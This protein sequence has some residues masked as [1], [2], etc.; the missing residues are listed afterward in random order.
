MPTLLKVSFGAQPRKD[1]VDVVFVDHEGNTISDQTKGIIECAQIGTSVPMPKG[2]S[3]HRLFA[4]VKRALLVVSVDTKEKL[5]LYDICALGG[6]VTCILQKEH[7]TSAR[8]FCESELPTDLNSVV[9]ETALKEFIHGIQTPTYHFDDLKKRQP[10]GTALKWVQ[11]LSTGIKNQVAKEIN[12]FVTRLVTSEHL[13]RRWIDTPAGNG[14]QTEDAV[15]LA[16]RI[17]EGAGPQC[18]IETI[19]G[20]ELAR[21]GMH[22]LYQVGVGSSHPPAAVILRW[23]GRSSDDPYDAIIGKFLVHDTGGEDAKPAGQHANMKADMGGGAMALATFWNAV[24]SKTKV[25]LIVGLAVADNCISSTSRH[26]GTVLSIYKGPSVEDGHTDAE[27]RLALADVIR[28]VEENYGP[29]RLVTIATLTG[30]AC[31]ALGLD[32][33]ALFSKTGSMRKV[34]EEA[35]DRSG[36]PVWS[37]PLKEARHTKLLPGKAGTPADTSQVGPKPGGSITAAKFLLLECAQTEHAAHLD[38]A[39]VAMECFDRVGTKAFSTGYGP[40]L[41]SSI[42]QGFQWPE[43]EQS[44]P[45]SGLDLSE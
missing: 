21:I 39:P 34:I 23:T 4:G 13:S 27:G 29:E 35:S 6:R 33:A 1:G 3:S 45:I 42:L 5:D 24:Q 31:I 18:T 28:Y 38:V 44:R 19:V 8:I 22:A 9:P 25:N 12:A 37:M 15:A 41:L 14:M 40:A 26:P 16:R 43:S 2:K 17:C 32:F 20:G 7:F 10:K 30:A 11:I 36:N